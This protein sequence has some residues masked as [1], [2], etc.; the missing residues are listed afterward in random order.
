MRPT[1]LG[2]LLAV[3]LSA[4][5]A[6]MVLR[7]SAGYNAVARSMN[8][9]PETRERVEMLAREAARA[10]AAGNHGQAMKSL[11]RG[12]ALMRSA[13]WT[14]TMS[15]AASLLPAVDHAVWEPGQKITLSFK[16]LYAPD[17]GAPETISAKLAVLP[18]N[19]A[20]VP[21]A[22][23]TSA[24]GTFTVPS[25]LQAGAYRLEVALGGVPKTVDVIVAPGARARS[26]ALEQRIAKLTST[27]S[28]ARTSAE[29]LA[30]L[31]LRA[32]RSEIRP[33][34]IDFGKELTFA[35]D[36]VTILETGRDP[37]KTRVGDLHLAYVSK[38]DQTAQP[39]R[40]Y[41][42]TDYKEPVPLVVVLHGIGGDENVILARPGS[43]ARN[44]QDLADKYGWIL[45]APKGREPASLYRG[46]AEQD[47]LDVIAE[48]R[49][50]YSIDDR[51][52][53]LFGVSMGGFGTW[54]IA[55]NHPDL[56]A[57][58]APVAGGGNP[59]RMDSIKSIPQI[60]VH[61]DNDTTVLV[62][63]SRAMVEAARKLGTEV[64]Y[65]EV[66]GG[67]HDNVVFPNL[68]QIFEFFASHP[69]KP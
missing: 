47:V 5:D 36:L 19:G 57:A 61:G 59:A 46:T 58:L 48:A 17:D 49:K 24:G 55:Q 2:V 9:A 23:L 38:V 65:I 30:S 11:H 33:D 31:F 12:M 50:L 56:F 21:L 45:A 63:Q 68:A 44:I 52:I 14:P 53:Y 69:K 35:E 54:S 7:T 10:S 15:L 18:P 13:E 26:E 51:R 3:S 16:R 4:Q 32:D 28:P 64:K 8:L 6:G 34:M 29:Y 39:Y 42:P 62:T 37:L 1:V 41:V 60:V 25:S 27:P 43:Q 66:P 67:T 40:L 22:D 20:P